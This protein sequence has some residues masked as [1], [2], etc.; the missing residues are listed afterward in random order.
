M[1]R[2][3][4]HDKTARRQGVRPKRE[5]GRAHRFTGTTMRFAMM[6]MLVS[7]ASASWIT[8]SASV[9]TSTEAG[10]PAFAF[11]QDPT[12]LREALRAAPDS[13]ETRDETGRSATA[14]EESIRA[15]VGSYI[16]SSAPAVPI[17]NQIGAMAQGGVMIVPDEVEA[18]VRYEW[19]DFD[20]ATDGATDA[21]FSSIT[22]GLNWFIEAHRVKFSTDVI[23]AFDPVPDGSSGVGLL[24]DVVGADDQIVFRS[25]L[26]LR[27]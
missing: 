27:W 3:G 2:M 9:S 5:A 22:A 14:A 18:F 20:G 12:P 21:N 13:T 1:A 26:S 16:D 7:A 23:W 17:F 11:D 19:F 24:E 4:H 8:A 25:Q 15:L 10:G 6:I